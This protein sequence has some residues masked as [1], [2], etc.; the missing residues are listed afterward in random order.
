[1][2]IY[3]IYGPMFFGAAQKALRT[4]V[5]TK[6]DIKVIIINMEN[7]TMIDMTALVAF[8]SI[9]ENFKNN[10]KKL[11]ICGLSSRIEKKFAKAQ[12]VFNDKNL[13]LQQNLDKAIDETI[14]KNKI[15]DVT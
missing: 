10:N 13:V 9:I 7:V 8:K 5:S 6:E 11:V 2:A 14:Y 15:L 12:I 4:L 3:D 1:M